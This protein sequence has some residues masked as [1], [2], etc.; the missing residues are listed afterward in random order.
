M[1]TLTYL[2]NLSNLKD[3]DIKYEFLSQKTLRLSLNHSTNNR[4]NK[5]GRTQRKYIGIMNTNNLLYT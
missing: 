4:I 2:Q 1:K 3:K 5:K